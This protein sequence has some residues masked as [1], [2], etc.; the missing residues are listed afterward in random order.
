MLSL[1]ED[2][3][4]EHRLQSPRIHKYTLKHYSPI[5]A[6]WD[7]FILLLVIYTAIFTP[8]MT[9]FILNEDKR[10]LQQAALPFGLGL[11]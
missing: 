9:V 1:D 4:M 2:V 10:I 3:G 5:R 8:Y 7:W 6:V 11:D